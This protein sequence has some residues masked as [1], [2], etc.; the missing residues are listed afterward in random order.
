MTKPKTSDA[1]QKALER[2]HLPELRRLAR[3]RDTTLAWFHAVGSVLKVLAPK[4]RK[5]SI[6]GEMPHCLRNRSVRHLTD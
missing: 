5:G 6:E 4:S 1:A 2:R 3:R